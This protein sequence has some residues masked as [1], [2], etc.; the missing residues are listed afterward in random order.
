MIFSMTMIDFPMNSTMLTFMTEMS[1]FAKADVYDGEDFYS[2]HF[3]LKE[4]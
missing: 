4:T 2:E 3:D 1:K